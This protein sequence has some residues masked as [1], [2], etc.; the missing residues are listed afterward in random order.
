MSKITPLVLLMMVCLSGC[1]QAQ[2]IDSSVPLCFDSNAEQVTEAART[3][4]RKMDFSLEK[5]DPQAGY[6][7]TRPLTAAQFFEF[8]RQDNVDAATTA[9]ASMQSLR[10][11]VEV[12]LEPATDHVCVRCSVQVQKLSLPER[13][14]EGVQNLASA[15]TRSQPGFQTMDIDKRQLEKMEWLDA[16]RDLALEQRILQKLQHAL[17]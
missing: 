13:P 16:G 10:R 12:R 8:W 17:E 15:F 7:R 5:D 11:V 2:P 1:R 4:L 3:V 9:K 14:V 6:L